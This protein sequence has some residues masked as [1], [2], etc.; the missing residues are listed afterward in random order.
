[1]FSCGFCQISKN[2]FFTEHLWATASILREGRRLKQIEI[3]IISK[4]RKKK[5]RKEKCSYIFYFLLVALILFLFGLHFLQRRLI[6]H[7]IHTFIMFKH[8]EFGKH[9]WIDTSKL[10]KHAHFKISSRYEVFTGLF[11]FFSSLSFFPGRVSSRD[12]ISRVIHPLNIKFLNPYM[13]YLILG[14]LWNYWKHFRII[15]SPLSVKR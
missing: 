7:Y 6:F 12:E 4:L 13:V 15:V 3:S 5:I 2:T 14:T 8:A 9:T 1:M 11:F 10:K